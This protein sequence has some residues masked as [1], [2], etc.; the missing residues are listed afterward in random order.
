MS[1]NP[2]AGYASASLDK[3][4]AA[5]AAAQGKMGVALKESQNPHLKN[6][7][8]DLESVVEAVRGPLSEAGLAFTHTTI[9]GQGVV[10]IRCY[11]FHASGQWLSSDWTTDTSKSSGPQAWG[12]LLT[13]G[14][15]YTLMAITGIAPGEDDGEAAM[16][17]PPTPKAAP[18]PA[19]PSKTEALAYLDATLDRCRVSS[20][21]LNVWRKAQNLRPLDALEPGQQ[22][23]VADW[24]AGQKEE[25]LAG[26]RI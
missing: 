8:A 17:R 22:V 4:V 13:Y 12:S 15:R 10:T 14:R 26:L 20:E 3:L 23:K 2:Y 25:F 16:G 5:L 11:L 18:A 6:K 21:K 9:P 24:L 7:Y 19:E 1:E